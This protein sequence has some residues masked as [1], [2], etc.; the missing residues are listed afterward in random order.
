MDYLAEFEGAYLEDSYLIGIVAEGRNLRLKMLLALTADH[1]A[2]A[3]PVPGEAHC[4]R[5]GSILIE[6]PKVIE[7]HPGKPM[8]SRD[9]E[10]TLDLG[11]LEIYR[12]GPTLFRFRTDW[13]DATVD[14]P[15]V[16]LIVD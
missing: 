11:S 4:F 14:A 12:R 6:R 5:E 3:P 15:Q 16:S 8:L 9:A 1:A 13:F 7:W 10:D 2:Y